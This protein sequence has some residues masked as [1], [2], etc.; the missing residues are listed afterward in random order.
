[1]A[2]SSR[3]QLEQP[4]N[5]QE[6]ECSNGISQNSKKEQQHYGENMEVDTAGK[7]T[8]TT[9]RQKTKTDWRGNR[10]HDRRDDQPMRYRGD[11]PYHRSKGASRHQYYHKKNPGYKGHFPTKPPSLENSDQASVVP[12]NKEERVSIMSESLKN[13]SVT[14]KHSHRDQQT[15]SVTEKKG[16]KQR[17]RRDK[18]CYDHERRFDERV[19]ERRYRKSNTKTTAC[20]SNQPCGSD[21]VKEKPDFTSGAEKFKIGPSNSETKETVHSKPDSSKIDNSDK[22]LSSQKTGSNHDSARSSS[23]TDR[24]KQGKDYKRKLGPYGSRVSKPRAMPTV[25]SDELAQH[26]TAETYECMVCCDRVKGRDQVW[27]C[28]NCFHVFHLR[29]IKKWATAP[30]AVNT[31]EGMFIV[32]ISCNSVH[33]NYI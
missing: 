11:R 29:C 8:V 5:N 24:D 16:S 1:M 21:S 13:D 27:N 4:I 10:S 31:D 2:D 17:E 6:P 7:S 15:V 18:P 30:V 14:E 3:E 20:D 32:H 33:I 19:K 12:I 26:L 22:K 25:Q 28:Q 9:S 23:Q